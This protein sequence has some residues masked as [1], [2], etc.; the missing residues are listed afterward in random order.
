MICRLDVNFHRFHLDYQLPLRQNR[1]KKF[2]P[3]DFSQGF[4]QS[5]LLYC[6]HNKKCNVNVITLNIQNLLIEINSN[7]NFYREWQSDPKDRTHT[8]PTLP[9]TG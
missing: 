5:I 9:G 4:P 7:I 8:S 6:L 3:L 2:H 1:F